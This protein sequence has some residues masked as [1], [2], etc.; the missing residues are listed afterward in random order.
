MRRRRYAIVAALAACL[1][2]SSCAAP[3]AG[4]PPG[5]AQTGAI[6]AAVPVVAGHVDAGAALD[7]ATVTL[8]LPDGAVLGTQPLRDGVYMFQLAS[9]PE[10]YRVTVSGGTL[11]GRPFTGEL[12]AERRPD[13]LW[14][15]GP[16]V[17]WV[18]TLASRTME[19]RP[20]QGLQD[21]LKAVKVS[22]EI[23]ERIDAEFPQEVAAYFDNTAFLAAG[24][25]DLKAAV[26]RSVAEVAAGTRHS[27]LQAD[28]ARPLPI[29]AVAAAKF[30]G[31]N[32]AS[33]AVGTAADAGKDSVLSVFGGTND[34]GSAK[35]DEANK[36]L[37]DLLGAVAAVDREVRALQ[38]QVGLDAAFSDYNTTYTLVLRP[39]VRA[40]ENLD[41]AHK[42]F[43]VFARNPQNSTD[44]IAV[45]RADLTQRENALFAN[46]G[47]L[48][49]SWRDG[50]VDVMP[51]AA[52]YVARDKTEFVTSAMAADHANQWLYLDG[53]QSKM[54]A[55]LV[56]Y[57]RT[58]YAKNVPLGNEVIR[59]YLMQWQANRVQEMAA[60]RTV[61][62]NVALDELEV[63][64]FNIPKVT[65]QM[66]GLPAGSFI[67]R[68]NQRIWQSTVTPN[69]NWS[70]L[71][72]TIA[73]LETNGWKVASFEDHKALHTDAANRYRSFESLGMSAALDTPTRNQYF[74]TNTRKRG[75]VGTFVDQGARGGYSI[76]YAAGINGSYT[77]MV[78]DGHLGQLSRNLGMPN[79]DYLIHH[80]RGKLN[81][82]HLLPSWNLTRLR[83][84]TPDEIERRMVQVAYMDRQ[85]VNQYEHVYDMRPPN[86]DGQI[87]AAGL[88]IQLTRPMTSLEVTRMPPLS[89]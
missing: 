51:L 1:T 68:R 8:T 70:V 36:K 60:V 25:S 57:L 26:D 14:V 34:A 9:M 80:W 77:D 47:V 32:L 49:D 62:Q 39:Q 55:Y 7:G 28:A 16:E 35:L 59:G 86:F 81:T 72:A 67:D 63:P 88:S 82:N 89:R 13:S 53:V 61:S 20:G 58:K 42:N 15:G 48:L 52:R 22:L 37:D 64:A 44:A 76:G 46:P 2:L 73:R 50:I 33:W 11:D 12:R 10:S 23:P 17:N 65:T 78:N 18:S 75:E 6:G 38:Q 43:A 69:V 74:W 79:G 29:L 4:T 56:Y 85:S 27:Y 84:V 71:D 19:A 83:L 54:V 24:G 87:Y 3:S 31:S 40:I 66:A 21:A 45:F 41:T 5:A 30:I